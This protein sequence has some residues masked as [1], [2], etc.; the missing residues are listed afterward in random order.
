MKAKDII[1]IMDNWAK[2]MLIDSW[3]NTGFQIGDKNLNVENIL[4]A[5]DYDEKVF[6]RALKENCQMIINHHPII[7]K[8]LK[9]LTNNSYVERLIIK[10]IKN[11][12]VVYNA[13]SNLDLAIGGVNDQ[14][15]K[16]LDIKVED[17]LSFVTSDESHS[18]GY[19]RVGSIQEISAKEFLN[20]IK[21]RLDI[22]MLKVYGDIDKNIS[23]VA[24]CGG[25][26]AD[27]IEDAY[28]LG[29]ELYLTG[30]IKYHDSQLAEQL[31]IIVVDGG[32]FNTEKIILPVIKETLDNQ[33]NREI[34]IIVHDES[35]V[36]CQFY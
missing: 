27:F 10:T 6:E 26:G 23:S 35:S 18:F 16:L 28:N 31:G 7:F 13:H 9:T 14:L 24:V 34:N 17:Y 15:A 21:D 4:V 2:P 1:S 3:D 12:I 19:G 36:P 33:F 30:D 29:A 5:L 11:N 22:D 20:K 32:H 8:S 25:S